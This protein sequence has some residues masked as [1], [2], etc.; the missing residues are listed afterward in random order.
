MG[1]LKIPENSGLVFFAM[2]KIERERE[3]ERERETCWS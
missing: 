1:N 2:S 3:R